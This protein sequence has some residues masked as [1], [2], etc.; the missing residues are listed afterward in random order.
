MNRFEPERGRPTGRPRRYGGAAI[1]R[2]T[3]RISLPILALAL[4]SVPVPVAAGSTAI[5]VSAVILSAGNCRFRTASTTLDFG[6]LDPGN[7]ANVTVNATIG[8]RCNGGPPNVTFA[9]S[10]DDGLYE[11]GPGSPRMRHTVQTTEF[12]PYGI[13][14]SPVS[15]TVPRNTNQVLAVTGTVLGA[16]YGNAAAGAYSDTVTLTIL[17]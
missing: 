1:R 7:P 9:I 17:P 15:G 6:L 16:S 10:G 8:F 5:S 12:L 2:R 14:L 3:C 4:L 13:S 11:S